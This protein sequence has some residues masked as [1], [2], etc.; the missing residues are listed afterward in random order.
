MNLRA[1]LGTAAVLAATAGLGGCVTPH[2]GSDG[3]YA[4]PIGDAPVTGQDRPQRADDGEQRRVAVDLAACGRQRFANGGDA[5][6]ALLSPF[7]GPRL[8]RSAHQDAASSCIR[9]SSRPMAFSTAS[10]MASPKIARTASLASGL[11]LSSFSRTVGHSLAGRPAF[12]LAGSAAGTARE[13]SSS[14]RR[15]LKAHW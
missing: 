1:L 12:F 14:R 10:P 9:S 13:H 6:K 7:L 8:L 2:A 5:L 11:I 3:M 4:T 15:F